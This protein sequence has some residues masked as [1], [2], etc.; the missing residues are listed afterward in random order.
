LKGAEDTWGRSPQSPTSRRK[1]SETEG[2]IGGGRELIGYE[3]GEGKRR[4][5]GGTDELYKKKEL[6]GPTLRPKIR[7][8]MKNALSISKL[9]ASERGGVPP[10]ERNK[11]VGTSKR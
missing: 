7:G 8:E 5:Q 2:T 11:G 10:S 9:D 6:K 1:G 4:E 3:N